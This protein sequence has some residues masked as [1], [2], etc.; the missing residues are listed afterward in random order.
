MLKGEDKRR[1]GLFAADE[2]DPA[3]LPLVGPF[4]R[5]IRIA[6]HVLAF[7]G[8]LYWSVR[9]FALKVIGNSIESQISECSERLLC[10]TLFV[11]E[12]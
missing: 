3:R 12:I 9:L 10:F 2:D 8:L 6:L 1:T 5:L 4:W 11:W 7:G